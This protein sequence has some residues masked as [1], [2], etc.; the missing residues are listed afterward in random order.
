MEIPAAKW[1]FD[2]LMSGSRAKATSRTGFTRGISI[3]L[4]I[5][6]GQYIIVNITTSITLP[7][8]IYTH[9]DILISVQNESTLVP[10]MSRNERHQQTQ[11][12]LSYVHHSPLF[13]H[14]RYVHRL[15]PR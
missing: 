11:E 6:R 9:G 14:I 2:M 12:V 13:Y 15:R 3:L 7:I 4:H 10:S 8:D 1:S 5:P